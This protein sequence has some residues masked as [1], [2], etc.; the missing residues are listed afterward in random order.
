MKY[1]IGSFNMQRFGE[2]AHKDFNKIAEII[3]K[4][5]LDIVAFQEIFSGGAGFNNLFSD[6]IEHHLYGWDHCFGIPF[7]SSDTTKLINN[8]E[9]IRGEGYA[10]AWDSRKF[11]LAEDNQGVFE[12][13]IINSLTNNDVNVNCSFF[14]RTPYYIRLEPLYGGFFEFRFINIH[15]YQGGA[16][17]LSEIDKRKREYD[18]IVREIYPQLCQQRYGNFRLAYTIALG[19][20]NLNIF[21]PEV[22]PKNKN[23]YVS[24]MYN[25][26]AGKSSYAVLTLQS[27]LTTLKQDYND[28]NASS[29]I[30]D[31]YVN[32]YDHVTISPELSHIGTNNIVCEP[33][34]AVDKYCSG[35]YDYYLRNIS[36]H[37]PIVAEIDV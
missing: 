3:Y 20:Y 1:R 25:Y 23:C 35:D 33:I 13:R 34:Y 5:R 12:P 19:D 7:D 36:D 15:V 26:S 4:E 27:Q 10:Y 11:K 30:E 28:N 17:T 32:N 24:R 22:Q 37:L 9:P 16:D 14:A 6:C 2:N 18:T 8:G 31:N 21:N 29:N